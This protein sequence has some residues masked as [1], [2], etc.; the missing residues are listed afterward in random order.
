MEAFRGGLWTGGEYLDPDVFLYDIAYG[1]K[2][3]VD[4]VNGPKKVHMNLSCVSEKEDPK[5]GD[6]EEDKFGARSGTYTV[7]VQLGDTN[8]EMKDKM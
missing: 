2:R 4:G 1:V 8:D 7:T 6:K 5:T 3:V